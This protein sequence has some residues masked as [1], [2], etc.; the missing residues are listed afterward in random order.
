M[1]QDTL[2]NLDRFMVDLRQ[3]LSQGRKRI[4]LL[5]G[6][7]APMSLLVDEK[8]NIASDG[9]PLIPDVA[10]LTDIV[11]R[12]LCAGDRAVIEALFPD[13]D[14]EV[15]IETVL[16][17]IRRLSEAIEN[18]RI[19]G[20][21]GSEYGGLAERV[22]KAIGRIVSPV[23]PNGPNPYTELATWIGGTYR[24]HPVEIFTPNYDLL[25]EESFERNR[26]PYFDGFSGSHRPF[27]DPTSISSDSLP[28]RWSRL[29][30]IHGSLGWVIHDGNII[31]TG[32]RSAT[33]L[34][35]PDHLKYDRIE[36]QPYTAMFERLKSFLY[37]PDS[38]LLCTGFSFFDAHISAILDEALAANTHTA[39]IAF[40]FRSLLEEEA[41]KGLAIRRRNLSVYARDGGVIFGIE[42]KWRLGE[43][44]TEEW[45][46]IRNTFW[47][48][49]GADG[50]RFL[51]GDFANL[52]RFVALTQAESV[53]PVARDVK[54]EAL[55]VG[56]AE[57]V[58]VDGTSSM[59]SEAPHAES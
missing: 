34:I 28:A 15:N 50:G 36:K 1:S 55:R 58:E 10:R 33:G 30:K 49:G 56:A 22:C 14:G 40:Q 47:D 57:A 17:R 44:P 3:I 6:A 37:T 2:H 51:L 26:L 52:A 25:L 48:A 31:R 32:S 7:G 20:L 13:R 27:F 46:S 5:L 18:E 53:G 41:A 19:F 4:G 45:L 12:S 39:V 11:I 23:L 35:Y 59:A 8:N 42:G 38:L 43:P 21:D 9:S 29:W 54:D 16:T 24:D